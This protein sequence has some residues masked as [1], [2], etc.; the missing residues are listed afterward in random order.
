MALSQSTD[1]TMTAR[2]L[3]KHALRKLG[4]VKGDTPV[5][6]REH[7]DPA[8]DELNLMLKHWQNLGLMLWKMVELK[9]VLIKH[10]NRYEFGGNATNIYSMKKRSHAFAAAVSTDTTIDVKGTTSD[11]ANTDSIDIHLND[12]TIHSTTINGAP[13]GIAGGV[14][15]TLTDALDAGMDSG[16][17]VET[18]QVETRLPIRITEAVR[19]ENVSTTKDTNDIEIA[20]LTRQEWTTENDKRNDGAPDSI[21]FEKLRDDAYLHISPESD[22]TDRE[23]RLQAHMPLD[24]IDSPTNNVDVPNR[25][26]H[27]VV[28]QLASLLAD[29]YDNLDPN[30]VV[31]VIARAE[32]LLEETRDSETEYDVSL[33]FQPDTYWYDE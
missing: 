6:R 3:V 17:Q 27:T 31:R 2:D 9:V 1:F 13:A 19:R 5:V 22:S 26:L 11:F 30:R 16:A 10:K 23:L 12:G 24:D 32:Q 28:Y 33:H 25:Y 20:I 18:W 21:W 14:R 7:L 15:L 8:L 4:V 29:S